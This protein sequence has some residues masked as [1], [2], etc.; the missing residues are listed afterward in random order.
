MTVVQAGSTALVLLDPVAGW[1]TG[2]IAVVV[3]RCA[4][5]LVESARLVDL[6]PWLAQDVSPP[7]W[8][9]SVAYYSA[10]A[11]LLYGS[12]QG[13]MRLVRSRSLRLSSCAT[14]VLAGALIV[15]SPSGTS[16]GDMA[17]APP[18][19][20]RVVVLDVGQ[21]DATVVI[22]P[23][24][25]CL[26]IDAG[27]LAGTTF[28]IAGR[29]VLP[30]L[31]ALGVRRLHALVVTHGDPDHVGGA[32]GVMQRL[33]TLN[34]WEGVPVPPNGGLRALIARAAVMRTMWRTVRPGDV[35]RAAGV[36]IRVLHP[37][38]PDWERQRVRNDDSVVLEIS[39]R[40]V[41]ILLPGDIGADVERELARSLR[42]R[43]LVILKAAHHGS[44]TSSGDPFI[45]ATH[46]RAVIFS[47][48]RQNRF[49]HPAPAVVE[50]FRRHQ[51]EMFNTA[52][53]GA[54]FVE[55]DGTKVEV[56]GWTGRTRQFDL[57]RQVPQPRGHHDH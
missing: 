5:G 37:P 38:E 20:L 39:Y 28:D 49:G 12:T 55:T 3:H 34:V 15:L 43:P 10:C 19:T 27:G 50:R 56:R 30:A 26:L 17:P 22:L 16:S 11:G 33:R 32:D 29:V 21:G 18:D 47:A 45:D 14:L 48:G 2:P 35:E 53:D 51:V 40:D 4:T 46:P 36:D 7:A 6:A 9:L 8:W 25:T 23:D 42:L 44:A 13:S 31:R 41:S 24:R 54:V 57:D 1:A 52:V